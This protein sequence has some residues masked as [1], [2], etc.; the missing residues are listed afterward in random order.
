MKAN[1]ASDKIYIP[2]LISDGKLIHEWN[3]VPFKKFRFFL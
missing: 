3:D 1:E 2:R